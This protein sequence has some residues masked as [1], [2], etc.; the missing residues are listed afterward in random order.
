MKIRFASN[1]AQIDVPGKFIDANTLQVTTPDL[2]DHKNETILKLTVAMAGKIHTIM[3]LDYSVFHATDAT[4]CIA[5][6]PGLLSGSVVGHENFFVVQT[7][8]HKNNLRGVGDDQFTVTIRKMI[9]QE[10]VRPEEEEEEEEE[11]EDEEDTREKP[12]EMEWIVDP[13][14]ESLETKVKDADNGTHLFSYTAPEP[15]KYHIVISFDGTFGGAGGPLPGSPW[16]IDIVEQGDKPPSWNTMNGEL[17]VTEMKRIVTDTSRFLKHGNKMLNLA[18]KKGDIPSLLKVKGQ[19]REIET[20]KDEIDQKFIVGDAKLRYLVDTAVCD[21][22]L[23]TADLKTMKMQMDNFSDS[24]NLWTDIQK[25][26][27]PTVA[28]IKPVERV[29]SN[30][31]KQ[32]ADQF[33]EETVK[34]Q[35]EFMK[36]V[37]FDGDD[38]TV[39]KA[40]EGLAKA[41]KDNATKRKA[42]NQMNHM[43]DIFDHEDAVLQSLTI[44]EEMENLV[45]VMT[46][47]WNVRKGVDEDKDASATLVLDG[48][49][50]DAMDD[51]AKDMQKR[52]RKLAREVRQT[53]AFKKLNDIVKDY[54]NTVPLIATVTHPSMRPRHWDLVKTI[55]GKTFTPPY[56][57]KNCTVGDMLAL[58]LHLYANEVEELSDQSTKEAKMETQLAE[59]QER[60]AVVEFFLD[61]YQDTGVFM[62]KIKDDDNEVLENDQLTIQG[63]M[64]SRYLSTFEESVLGWQKS[65]ANIADSMVVLND[66]QRTWSYLEPLFMK[67]EEVKKE[68]PEDAKR[69]ARVDVDV[70]QILKVAAEDK[71][72]K[73]ALNKEGLYDELERLQSELERCKK[74]LNDFLDAKRRIFAR[75]YFMSESDLLDILSNGNNPRRIIHHCEKVFL[76]TKVVTFGDDP[77]GG[78]RPQC[79]NWITS[80]GIEE[81]DFEVP[82]VLKD[83]VEIYLQDV[84]NAM[85]STQKKLLAESAADFKVTSP[86]L[87]WILMK[88]SK[89]TCKGQDR[90]KTPAQL[91]LYVSQMSYCANTENLLAKGG[92]KALGEYQKKQLEDLQALVL[93]T[94]KELRKDDRNRIMVLI[95][96][97]AHNR[98][99]LAEL[100]HEKVEDPT[101]FQWSRQLRQTVNAEGKFMVRSFDAEFEYGY[102]YLGNGGRLVVTPL[103][104]RIYC[105]C[106]QAYNLKMGCAPAGPAGTGKTETTKDL[107]FALAVCIYVFNC[108]PEMDYISMGN[109]FKGLAASGSWGCFD[110]FNRLRLEVLSVCTVQYKAV[111]DVLRSAKSFPSRVTINGDEVN[112]MRTVMGIITMNPGYAGRA[113]LPEGLKAL[114]RPMTVMVPDMILIIENMLM[115]EGFTEAKVLASKFFGLYALLKDLLSAQKHYD[116]GLRA[117]KSVLRV[118]G[119]YLRGDPDMP[120]AALLMRALRDSN[121]AKILSQDEPIF[122]GLLKDLFPGINPPRKIDPTLQDACK[123]AA[124]E[125]R[126][127]PSDDFIDRAMQLDEILSIRHC[128]FM[129]GPPGCGRTEIIRTLAGANGVQG[130]KTKIEY[131]NPKAVSCKELY[132]YITAATREWRD[133][134]LSKLM[135]DLGLMPDENPKWIVLDGDLDTLWIESMNSVMDMNKTLT[136]AS[137]ERIP[138][139]PHMRMVFEPRDLA[140]ASLA[141]VTRAGVLYVSDDKGHQGRAKIRQWLEEREEPQ[142]LRDHLNDLA[143]KYVQPVLI[144]IKKYLLHLVPLS[145][146]AMIISLLNNLDCMLKD[147]WVKATEDLPDWKLR[148]ETIFVFCAVWGFGGAFD[149]K[150]GINYRQQF[151]DYWKETFRTVKFPARNSIYEVWLDEEENCFIPWNQS[152]QFQEISFD[153][154]K[155][156]MSQI[157]VPTAENCAVNFWMRMLVDKKVPVMLVGPAGCGKTQL[158][159]GLLNGLNPEV[160]ISH[161]INMN[162]FTTTNLLQNGLEAPLQKKTGTSYGP[163]GK[164]TLIYFLD[165]LNLPEKD[166]YDTQS[167]ISLTRMAM[168]YTRWSD[169]I[170]LTWKNIL[171]CQWISCMNPTAGCFYVN[172]RL[173][174]RFA[175]Y[176]MGFPLPSSLLQIFSTFLSGHLQYFSEDIQTACTNIINAALDLQ[177]GVTENFRKSAI[178]FHYE[179]NVR[180]LANVFVGLIVA[181]PSEFKSIAKIVQLWLHES[182]RVYGDRLVSLEHVSKYNTIALNA[183]KKRFPGEA[184]AISNFY[185]DENDDQ[186]IFCH[187]AKTLQDNKYDQVKDFKVLSNTLNSALEDYNETNAVMAL[188]LFKDAVKH[189]CRITRVINNESGHAL[190]VGVGGSGKQSLSRLSSYICGYSVY[191]ITINQT[192]GVKDFLEDMQ[193]MFM[194]AGVKDEGISFLFTDS[195]VKDEKF[196]VYLNDL[197]SSGNIPD[198]FDT[199]GVDAIINGVTSKVKAEGLK[200][201][202]D[203]CWDFFL[204]KIRENLHV[205]LCFSPVGEDFRNRSMRF[206]ALINSTAIDWFHAWPVSALL[207][208]ARGVMSDVDFGGDPKVSDSVIQFMPFSF[209][210]VNKVAVEFRNVEQRIVYTTP[211]SFLE[212]LSLYRTLLGRKREESTE[213]IDRLSNGLQKL[214]DTAEM[215]TQLAADLEIMLVDANEKKAVAEE[216]AENVSIEKATVGEETAK[217]EIEEEKVSVIAAEANRIAKDASEDLA[218]AEPAVEN[219]MKALDSLDKKDLGEAKTMSKPPGGVDDIFAAVMVLLANVEPNVVCGKNGKVKDRSWGAAKKQLL[220]NIPAFIDVLKGFKKVADDGQVPA[221]NWKEVRPYLEMDHFDPEVIKTKNSAAAGLCSW[222]IN[223][224]IYYDIVTTVEPKRRALADAQAKLETA[225]TKLKVVKDL[226][227]ELS[228]KLKKLTDEF[229]AANKEKNDAIAIVENGQTKLSLATRLT[230]ALGSEGVRWK[231]NIEQ[232]EAS[233]DLLVGDVLLASAFLSYIGPFTKQYRERLLNEEWTP[234][235]QKA[236]VPLSENANPTKLLTTPAAVAQWNQDKLP[237]DP[238]SVENGTILTS[239]LRFPLM[240]DPQLQGIEWIRNKEKDHNLV[241][242]RMTEKSMLRKLEQAMENGWA[243]MIEN[244]SESIDAV[245]NP[246]ISRATIKKGRK[247][248]I[249]LG[250]SEIE[251]HPKFK[252]YLHTKL[253][254]PHYPPEIQAEAAMVNFSVTMDGLE[255]QLLTLIVKEE[256]P[257]LASERLRLIEMQN[258]FKIKMKEL[259]DE[260][261]YK[262]ATAEGDITADVELIEGLENTKLIALDIEKKSAQGIITAKLIDDISEKYRSV[263]ARGSLL[264]FLMN[265]LFKVHTYYAFS[266]EAFVIV[267]LR[268]IHKTGDPE[269]LL[270]SLVKTEDEQ[271]PEKDEGDEEDVSQPPEEEINAAIARRCTDL[272]SSIT[273]NVW[274]YLRRGLF[275]PDKLTIATQLCFKILLKDGKLPKAEVDYLIFNNTLPSEKPATLWWC[276]DAIWPRVKFV[277]KF[278][279]DLCSKMEDDSD[280]WRKWYDDERPELKAMPGDFSKIAEFKRIL[281]LRALRPDRLLGALSTYVGNELGEEFVMQPPYDMKATYDETS[282]KI[283]IFFVLFPGVDPTEWVETLGRTMDIT[284]QNGKFVNVSMGEG[285]EK[286]AAATV[287]KLSSTGGWVMLQNIHLMV[288]WLPTLERQLEEVAVHAHESFRCFLSAEPPAFSYQK[289]IPESLLQISIKVANDAPADIKSNLVR[290]WSEFPEEW[291]NE[292]PQVYNLRPCL[293]TLCFY[294]AVIQGRRRFGQQ[295][296]SIKYSF[297]TGDLKTCGDVLKAWIGRATEVP[298]TDIR[299]ILSGIMYGGHI[300]DYWDRRCNTTYLDV[301]LQKDIFTGFELG[302]EFFAPNPKLE[303]TEMTEH[304]LKTLPR[305]SPPL[306]RMHPNAEIGYL[307]TTSDLLFTVIMQVEV[308]GGGGSGGGGNTGELKNTIAKLTENLPERFNEVDIKLRAQDLLEGPEAPFVLVCMQEV[309]RMNYLTLLMLDSMEQLRKGLNGELNMTKQMEDLSAALTI[310]QVPG[311]NIFSSMSWEA[312]AWP[313]KRTLR[314]WYKDIILRIKQLADWQESLQRPKAVWIPGLFNP[315]AF[316]T[317]VMQATGRVRGLALDTMTCET[318]PTVMTDTSNCLSHPED[319]AY[320]HGLF[321]EGARWGAC[322]ALVNEDDEDEEDEEDDLYEV[323][324]VKCGGHL[325]DSK[326]KEL[327]PRMPVMYLKAVPTQANWMATEVGYIR[328]NPYIYECPIYSTTFRGNTYIAMATLKCVDPQEKWVLAAAALIMQEDE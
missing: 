42:Y 265:N 158:V 140:Q 225:S 77:D 146:M 86:R 124:V 309:K 314:G 37:F 15:G 319:G 189:I 171:N 295:G 282:P 62:V 259:E 40:M 157:C 147:K 220:G 156:I 14:G 210:V 197:L 168:Q 94:R 96:L 247:L 150:D 17:L 321:I 287:A 228:A 149:I 95:T 324:G 67:S 46:D 106:C 114:F 24:A 153:S 44:L 55:T 4:K 38:T 110:E 133:G 179:F 327:L 268:G 12:K 302:H 169:R 300:T 27:K 121:A 290:A 203:I 308:G 230:N 119:G 181:Q 135:R 8:D 207:S 19:L 217:A 123:Q 90:P 240:I 18:V 115:A 182:E 233:R 261:L 288:H 165:D 271:A 127:W 325:C 102:E 263:A 118:A 239:T 78:A 243:F 167:A 216:I 132:G 41:A 166:P 231:A 11:E 320:I 26:V 65:L 310:N 3:S 92:Y 22:P 58:E 136:L 53:K 315:M 155:E 80:N 129:L 183:V 303:Y 84:H 276:P 98:D 275:E 297:N 28:R 25:N 215:V 71:F 61:E 163:P 20:R 66:V 109:I 205:I 187:F 304:I 280:G 245:L 164:S 272:I 137:N 70:K 196:L 221:I 246:V 266:L 170:K 10:I 258:G 284:E 201:E 211:K 234:F 200:P 72:C 45:V 144:Q 2:T 237:P 125:K 214:N 142:F 270:M 111:L 298:W 218:K 195:Q 193:K 198:L 257:D 99:I 39:E 316:V 138:L 64:G 49:D 296:W 253:S 248:Y 79:L 235:L 13:T 229:D 56:E 145:D 252:L 29:E 161:S 322:S 286:P 1:S 120:E 251:F 36:C 47:L 192:Y 54:V 281:I 139:K 238:V 9:E 32:E 93:E 134:L 16:Q 97:D 249:K 264:F 250:D 301:L 317:A 283:P 202:N 48:M 82:F 57:D 186:L 81:V 116:W 180:H 227:A 69:F 291:V 209:D 173:Q 212:L 318:H 294:H 185:S 112:C 204:R 159:E 34:Y 73:I 194:K 269:P 101:Q 199:E 262:L 128:V 222:V 76:A 85:V 89:Q 208:V 130:R 108:S 131:V 148:I 312:F 213:S 151:N 21:P 311:R 154:K 100:I 5:F 184:G 43:T 103:T 35:K 30:K 172:P 305:D 33:N 223:I 74:A 256:R 219:A 87:K 177:A 7:R 117:V 188:V 68:L 293:F 176:A 160:K 104:D 152:P 273:S 326:L 6:G 232:M 255:D 190:L 206:P 122:F 191:Q 91:V 107:A 226:V 23:S 126:L 277:N 307:S 241:I 88:H 242:T 289:I 75:F 254:N 63:M 274:Q 267:F 83:N 306:Y 292:S 224:V 279:G 260:I 162:Y 178:N 323:S 105:T 328:L 278:F 175:T 174:L 313:S 50:P 143:T 31:V 141:T 59:L 244:L 285:Q 60:W 51:V 236:E 52:M 299:Y 113:N